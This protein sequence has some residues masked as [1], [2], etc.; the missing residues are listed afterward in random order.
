MLSAVLLRYG[1]GPRRLTGSF[2][3]RF[4]SVGGRHR[5]NSGRPPLEL[6]DV[7]LGTSRRSTREKGIV[8]PANPRPDA[9]SK[10]CPALFWACRIHLF[11]LFYLFYFSFTSIHLVPYGVLELNRLD[12][13][14]HV[15]KTDDY[16]IVSPPARLWPN[17][18]M[19]REPTC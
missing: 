6:Q 7:P 2:A 18:A 12:Q 1:N 8:H 3:T 15:W 17:S 4:A 9:W 14:R 5:K 11:I 10:P 16:L 13:T 19:A